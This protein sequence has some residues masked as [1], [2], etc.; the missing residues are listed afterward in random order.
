MKNDLPGK[1]EAVIAM[2]NLYD[3]LEELR[4]YKDQHERIEVCGFN[5]ADEYTVS[6]LEMRMVEYARNKIYEESTRTYHTC[7]AWR[8]EETG[9]IET[10][11]YANW[12][13]YRIGTI[14]SFMSKNQFIQQF[15]YRLKADYE[16]EKQDAIAK[17]AA[18]GD[19]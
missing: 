5:D 1:G 19:E 10:E 4:R 15:E 2:I 16:S 13:R 3:E 14:P 11:Q 12:L 17:L 9:E 6:A 7:G 8:D 18:K